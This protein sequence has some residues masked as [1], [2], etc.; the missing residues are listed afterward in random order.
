V[1]IACTTECVRSLSQSAWLLDV[2]PVYSTAVE[3]GIM[4]RG[5]VEQLVF[6]VPAAGQDGVHVDVV[7]YLCPPG[8]GADLVSHGI[9]R[10]QHWPDRQADWI[11][12]SPVQAQF[13]LGAFR[14]RP[15]LKAQCHFHSA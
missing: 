7:P 8:R 9:V 6:C 5:Q 10:V 1:V 12:L 14:A 13:D 2:R 11:V 15:D 4:I 3:S